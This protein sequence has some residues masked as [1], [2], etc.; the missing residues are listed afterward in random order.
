MHMAPVQRMRREQGFTLIELMIASLLTMVVMGVA[1]STFNNALQ[2]NE[3]VQNL[4][5]ST[6]NLRAGTNIL[7]RDLMQAGRE[8]DIGGIGIPSGTGSTAIYRPS[9]NGVSQ[10]FFDNTTATTLPA[11]TTGAG[12]GPAVDGQSTDV[13]TILM[14]DPYLD[15]L[16]VY[17]DTDSDPARAHLAFDGSSFGVGTSSA[18]VK[19]LQGDTAEEIPAIKEGDLLYFIDPNGKSTIQTVTGVDTT[20]VDFATGDPFKFNQP[21]AAA[22]SI[23]QILGQ[24]LTV[25]RIY[26]YTYYVQ[27]DSDSPRLMRRLNMFK[28]T[29]LAGVVEDL[30]LSYD[31]SDGSVNP[32]A[33]ASLPYTLEGAT[34][35]ANQIRKVNVHVGVRSE[36]KSTRTNDYLRNHVSTVVSIRNLAYTDRYK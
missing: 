33:V 6:Q 19:W 15:D 11:L 24:T 27:I 9:P 28:A 5:D 26:M 20:R 34:Y 13:I 18:N 25:R 35:T 8:I 30:E 4:A 14:A 3:S 10:L 21:D 2:L 12:K 36:Q 23:T 16:L 32:V 31:L 7:V 22:G 1:F 29:A 17:P